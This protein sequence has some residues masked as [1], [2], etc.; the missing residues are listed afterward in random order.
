[1]FGHVILCR[2]LLRGEC[3][4]GGIVIKT[5]ADCQVKRRVRESVEKKTWSGK[6]MAT[7][8]ER[9]GAVAKMRMERIK[10]EAKTIEAGKKEVANGK[11]ENWEGENNEGGKSRNEIRQGGRVPCT[12]TAQWQASGKVVKAFIRPPL[13]WRIG[14]VTTEAGMKGEANCQGTGTAP[15]QPC[16][17]PFHGAGPVATPG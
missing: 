10:S 2:A 9:V 15:T 6:K 5:R 11:T 16:T 8:K 13:D 12:S 1:M 7:N 17:S 3:I 14:K 4:A